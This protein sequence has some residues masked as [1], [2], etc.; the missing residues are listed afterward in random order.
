MMRK[1]GGKLGGQ[2]AYARVD[3]SVKTTSYD[4]TKYIFQDLDYDLEVKNE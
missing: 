3:D 2:I 4:W 1:D